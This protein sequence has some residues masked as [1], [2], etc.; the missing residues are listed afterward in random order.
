MFLPGASAPGPG[1]F[2]PLLPDT[3]QLNV[4]IFNGLAEFDVD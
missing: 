1:Q 2:M 4:S 3:D